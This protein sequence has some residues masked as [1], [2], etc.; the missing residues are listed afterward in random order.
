MKCGQGLVLDKPKST[1]ETQASKSISN[2]AL[3]FGLRKLLL[4]FL[5]WSNSIAF[6]AITI[7]SPNKRRDKKLIN[8]RHQRGIAAGG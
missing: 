1:Q 3:G 2:Y 4:Y 6:L 5:A 8:I 7:L